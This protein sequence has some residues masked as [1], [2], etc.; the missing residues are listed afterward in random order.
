MTCELL[1]SLPTLNF[2]EFMIL[3]VSFNAVSPLVQ[4]VEA[5]VFQAVG[6]EFYPQ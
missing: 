1:R 2:C 6:P 3:L 5:C 4:V